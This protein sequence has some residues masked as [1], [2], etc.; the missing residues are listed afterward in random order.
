LRPFFRSRSPGEFFYFKIIFRSLKIYSFELILPLLPGEQKD[1]KIP[2]KS[3]GQI[4]VR[5]E[6]VELGFYQ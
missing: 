3:K 1:Q 2:A 6:E 4:R 5:L